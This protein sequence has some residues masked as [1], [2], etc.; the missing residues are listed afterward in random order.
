MS[1]SAKN[2]VHLVRPSRCEE[3]D[4]EGPGPS[5]GHMLKSDK[6]FVHRVH[7][8]RSNESKGVP[9]NFHWVDVVFS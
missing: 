1:K 8:F 2:L 3:K 6:K 7:P 4:L 5:Q 9:S